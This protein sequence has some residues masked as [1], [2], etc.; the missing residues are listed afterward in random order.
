LFVAVSTASAV[1]SST[2]VLNP[3]K[4]SMRVGI[5]FQTPVNVH[6]VTS[7]HES[8]MF[9]TASAMANPSQKGF[10]LLLPVPSEESVSMTAV[11][12]RNVFLK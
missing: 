4:S 5:N 11:A 6:I 12:L 8:R 7:S 3:S 1:T 9:V 2:E 10:N